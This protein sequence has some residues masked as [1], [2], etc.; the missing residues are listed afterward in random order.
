[1]PIALTL[2][3]LVLGV[4]LTTALALGI[5]LITGGSLVALFARA[6]F[7]ARGGPHYPRGARHSAKCC[8]AS[9]Q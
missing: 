8:T 9:L 7:R 4:R 6:C 2:D 3:F 5:A 1:M